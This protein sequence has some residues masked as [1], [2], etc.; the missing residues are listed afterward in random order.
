MSAAGCLFVKKES[1]FGQQDFLSDKLLKLFGC[2]ILQLRLLQEDVY[3]RQIS[4]SLATGERL[5]A[6][7]RQTGFT[8]MMRAA[9]ET[10][11]RMG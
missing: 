10:A 5:S 2:L 1:D 8:D 3:K 9:L 4:D 11:R 6:E 7:E